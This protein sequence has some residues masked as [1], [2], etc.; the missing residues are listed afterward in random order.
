MSHTEHVVGYW[1]A[2]AING[3]I[4][5]SHKVRREPRLRCSGCGRGKDEAGRMVSGPRVYICEACSN[6]AGRRLRAAPANGSCSFCG[7]TAHVAALGPDARHAICG[8]CVELIH[9]IFLED[10]QRQ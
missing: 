2:R 1:V 8:E 9:E 7:K 4:D 3:F 6:D 10:D 5:L